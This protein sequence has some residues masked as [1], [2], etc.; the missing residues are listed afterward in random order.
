MRR[1]KP[2]PRPDR[3]RSLRAWASAIS[4]F[5]R[6]SSARST[7]IS[8]MAPALKPMRKRSS[9]RDAVWRSISA[10]SISFCE[11]ARPCCTTRSARPTSASSPASVDFS[12]LRRLT[13]SGLV[14]S[15]SGWPFLTWSPACT[16]SWTMPAATA[17]RLGLLAAV[18][19]PSAAMS[20]TSVPRTTLA[21]RTRSRSTERSPAIQRR[22]PSTTSTNSASAMPPRMS[23][24]RAGRCAVALARRTS[25]FEVSRIMALGGA[26]GEDSGSRRQLS[27]AASV[28]APTP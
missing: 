17:Y 21:M 15:A 16:L 26:S 11:P 22:A 9:S 19:R 1:S 10:W 4:A 27:K 20:R 7:S 25:W 6:L 24:R 2:R 12:W 14:T 18:T 13:R 23:Q 3:T 28:P 5:L 8:G